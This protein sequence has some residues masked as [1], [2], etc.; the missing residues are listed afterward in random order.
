LAAPEALGPIIEE[1]EEP[2]KGKSALVSQQHTRSGLSV[3]FEDD[4]TRPS[5]QSLVL[6]G[7]STMP[8][9]DD[10]TGMTRQSQS[11]E[12]QEVEDVDSLIPSIGNYQ[13]QVENERYGDC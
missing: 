9:M 6:A 8:Q 12:Q 10:P 3:S 5:R 2:H 4:M 11:E 13:P 7:P 1:S